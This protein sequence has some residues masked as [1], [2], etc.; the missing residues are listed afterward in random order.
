[1]ELPKNLEINE[2]I[3]ELKKSKQLSFGLIY[4]LGLIELKI[5]KTYIKTKLINYFI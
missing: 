5:L 4:N 1:M 3:I 2:Y